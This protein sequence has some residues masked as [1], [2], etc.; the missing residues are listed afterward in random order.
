[1][2]SIHMGYRL[3]LSE[4]YMKKVIVVPSSA[5]AFCKHAFLE[6]DNLYVL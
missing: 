3:Y 1:M 2:L 4:I 6:V 5:I